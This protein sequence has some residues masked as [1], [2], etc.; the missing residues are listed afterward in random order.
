MSAVADNETE[1]LEALFDQIAAGRAAEEAPAAVAAVAPVAP[2][3]PV[4]E[5]PAEGEPY[6]I[7]H[8]VGQLTRNLHD[9]LRELGYDKNID[10]AVGKLPDARESQHRAVFR[11]GLLLLELEDLECA[12]VE[13]GER[14]D[15]P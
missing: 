5:A 12:I 1:D 10:A 8:R 4:G 7:F 11:G 9:A 13:V 14:V 2:A 15:P 3:A 6:D